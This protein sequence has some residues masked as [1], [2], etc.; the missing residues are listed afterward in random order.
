MTASHGLAGAERAEPVL[1]PTEPVRRP[2][3]AWKTSS[4]TELGVTGVWCQ[5]F[6]SFPSHV[7]VRFSVSLPP[8]VSDSAPRPA[9]QHGAGARVREHQSG[10]TAPEEPRGADDPDPRSTPGGL[11]DWYGRHGLHWTGARTRSVRCSVLG[12]VRVR[13]WKESV[14]Q[15]TSIWGVV[16]SR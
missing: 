13:G 16:E 2:S 12:F 3:W 10:G 7:D 14:F 15:A 9:R 8:C 11:R 5:T 6:P 1:R 4:P